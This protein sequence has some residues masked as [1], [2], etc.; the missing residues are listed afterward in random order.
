MGV[1]N[2]LLCRPGVSKLINLI[3]ITTPESPGLMPI[4]DS[5]LTMCH[6]MAPNLEKKTPPHHVGKAEGLGDSLQ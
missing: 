4:T 3:P 6:L 5:E 1:G 2:K